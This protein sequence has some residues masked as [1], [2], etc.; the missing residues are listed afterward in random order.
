[1]LA[2]VLPS[3]RDRLD[4]LH[5]R[6]Q[7]AIEDATQRAPGFVH[8]DLH[9]RQLIVEGAEVIGLLDIDECGL[10]D[11]VDDIAVPVAHLRYRALTAPNAARI[12]RYA[13]NLIAAT[14]DL[15]P[16]TATAVATAAVLAGL[17]TSSFRA[18]ADNWQQRA[19]AVLDL[20]D[21]VLSAA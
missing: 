7:L 3:E 10:G 4:R 11:P 16:A 8:G 9:E 2:S 18:Q 15:V 13:D 14:A 5:D 19:V 12:D 21:D 17:A 20:I 6:L 1:L